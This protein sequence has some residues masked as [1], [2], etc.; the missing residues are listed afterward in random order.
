M[1]DE[2]RTEIVQAALK[3]A[4]RLIQLGYQD[5]FMALSAMSKMYEED[6]QRAVRD[7]ETL[8]VQALKLREAAA[9]ILDYVED[10]G[11][12]SIT[13]PKHQYPMMRLVH[14]LGRLLKTETKPDGE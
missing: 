6:W 13:T 2:Q 11:M 10:H 5:E 4:E 8:G 7:R 9:A 14:T 3:A 1:H 12:N